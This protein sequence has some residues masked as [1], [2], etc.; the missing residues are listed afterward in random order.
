[1]MRTPNSSTARSRIASSRLIS[2]W[3]AE[4]RGEFLPLLRMSLLTEPILAIGVGAKRRVSMVDLISWS[5]LLGRVKR[6]LG[7]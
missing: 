7:G 5:V 6:M 1:M 3:S 4:I 2:A